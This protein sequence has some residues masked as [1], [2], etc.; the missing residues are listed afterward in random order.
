MNKVFSWSAVEEPAAIVEWLNGIQTY[1]VSG[2]KHF[3]FFHNNYI[4]G[5]FLPIDFH[6]IQRGLKPPTRYN[7]VISCKSGFQ[8]T[9]KWMILQVLG[10][11][12]PNFLGI[13]G[14][15]Q[16]GYDKHRYGKWMNMAHRNR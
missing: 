10:L 1:P 9:T 13:L 8:L 16:P 7:R 6:I 15:T 3:L 12:S 2:F 11:I 5:I 4:Y 14:I